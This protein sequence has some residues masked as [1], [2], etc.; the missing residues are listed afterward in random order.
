MANDLHCEGTASNTAKVLYFEH[1]TTKAW[2][3]GTPIP[4]RAGAYAVNFAGVAAGTYGNTL[5]AKLGPDGTVF[6]LYS[7]APVTVVNA[8]P[9]A[10]ATPP[11]TGTYAAATTKAYPA[12]SSFAYETAPLVVRTSVP[13]Y[14]TGAASYLIQNRNF[15][16][17]AGSWMADIYMPGGEQIT[18]DRCVFYSQSADDIAHITDHSRVT[19]TNCLFLHDP[20]RGGA[21]GPRAVYAYHA[22][23]VRVQNCYFLNTG[24]VMVDGFSDLF[25]NDADS[26]QLLNSRFDNICGDS[27]GNYRQMAQLQ[28]VVERPGLEI[29]YNQV[30][31]T[32]GQSRVE[33]NI[34]LGNASGTVA[35]PL[36]VHNNYV[37]GAYPAV[38]TDTGFTGTGMTTDA[39]S[40]GLPLNV[41]P[42]NIV[43]EK[44]YFVACLNAAMNIAAGYDVL[45]TNNDIVTSAKLA[46][47]TYLPS[48]NN[49]VA[50]FRGQAYSDAQFHNN[51]ITGNR[52]NFVPRP[53]YDHA[54]D[55]LGPNS[56]VLAINDGYNTYAST[57]TY[58]DE[59]AAFAAWQNRLTAQQVLIGP[60][61]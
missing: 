31:N 9:P 37:E 38:P 14:S 56:T 48:A 61:S 58:Q 18:I 46:D 19:F 12:A 26:F 20:L 50:V 22:R 13:A 54:G 53:F 28:N 32:P 8:P 11:P 23:K 1:P 29:G 33:D 35:S 44:N 59:R 17:A 21:L 39:N 10:T 25:Q 4:N 34:N 6:Y 52:I 7:G 41:F 3:A 16:V 2:A 43:A 60:L 5:R 15:K 30:V 47:G 45:Y 36:R 24:G 27:G 49:A 51:R 55:P 57:A 42:H 40:T